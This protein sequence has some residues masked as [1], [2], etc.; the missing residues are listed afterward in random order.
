MPPLDASRPWNASTAGRSTRSAV[1][2]HPAVARLISGACLQA[3]LVI[4]YAPDPRRSRERVGA[5]L[6]ANFRG[7][8]P[9]RSRG[10]R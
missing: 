4:A 8:S 10:R 3:G 9:E 5:A 2:P 6:E 1:G 7:L